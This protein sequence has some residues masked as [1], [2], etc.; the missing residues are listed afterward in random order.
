[1]AQGVGLDHARGSLSGPGA[2]AASADENAFGRVAGTGL[3]CRLSVDLLLR[4]ENLHDG[5]RKVMLSPLISRRQGRQRQDRHRRR[6]RRCQV[7]VLAAS[8]HGV[9]PKAGNL[10]SFF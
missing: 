7:K 2:F 9:Q 4:A 3:G 1:M 8:R 6:S 10:P 5:R